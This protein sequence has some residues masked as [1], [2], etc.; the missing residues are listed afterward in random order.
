MASCKDLQASITLFKEYAC[1][2]ELHSTASKFVW[3]SCKMYNK[4]QI[5]NVHDYTTLGFRGEE[6]L[7]LFKIAKLLRMP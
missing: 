5:W 1:F 7:C 3:P 2:L 4:R 6:D